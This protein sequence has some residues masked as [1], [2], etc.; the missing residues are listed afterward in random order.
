MASRPVPR[1]LRR[2]ER[3]SGSVEATGK[4]HITAQWR[5]G[6]VPQI[7]RYDSERPADADKFPALPEAFTE[8]PPHLLQALADAGNRAT[9]IP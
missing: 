2:E 1:R 9:R 4:A 8:N 3:R 6:N 7:V 5:D